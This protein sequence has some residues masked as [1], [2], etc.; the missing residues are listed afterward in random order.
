MSEHHFANTLKRVQQATFVEYLAT[1]AC[2]MLLVSILILVEA[3]TMFFQRQFA[4]SAFET[5]H[6]LRS[7]LV[8]TD[9]GFD[10][11]ERFAREHTDLAAVGLVAVDL[12][13]NTRTELVVIYNDKQV[14]KGV[15]RNVG[16]TLP[17]FTTDTRNNAE[18]ASLLNGEFGCAPASNSVLVQM[19]KLDM[20]KTACRVP[21][22]P[23]YGRLTGYLVMYSRDEVSIYEAEQLRKDA[24]KL[25]VDM[26]FATTSA[27]IDIL[28][29]SQQ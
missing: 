20:L 26:Y 29:R 25:S 7:R 14:E 15:D 24:L 27:T 6:V 13:E 9:A 10:A 18:M 28:T 12:A 19:H 8:L 3:K 23:Y 17:L 22:P 5:S 2:A 1:I 21:V 4:P 16:S 11:M